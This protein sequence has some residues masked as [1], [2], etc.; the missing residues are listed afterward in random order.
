MFKMILRKI[1]K[2][3]A[4]SEFFIRPVLKLHSLCYEVASFMVIQLEGGTHPKHRIMRYK[5][6]FLDNINKDDVILDIGCNTGQMSNLIS[7]K[8]EF[9]YGIDIEP[10]LIVEAKTNQRDNIEFIC[11]DATTYDYANCRPISC[12]TLSNVLEH[13]EYRVDFLKSLIKGVP[14]SNE[15]DKTLLIRVPMI[16]RD[17]ITIYKNEIGI[18][19][20]LDKSHFVEYTFDEF[21][22]ELIQSDIEILSYRIKFGEIYAICQVK[23]S[24]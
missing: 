14:W 13:I 16:D 18:D 4:F 10:R 5:E 1:T 8:A 23:F 12:I 6:W 11:A 3:H 20:R 17:W 24:S 19:S 9:V 15:L 7:Q 2:T 21:Q 22:N